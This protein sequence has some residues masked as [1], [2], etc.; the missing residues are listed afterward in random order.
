[1]LTAIVCVLVGPSHSAQRMK[2]HLGD[3]EIQQH[4]VEMLTLLPT[5]GSGEQVSSL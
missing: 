2:I 3:C 1:M 4:T 5:L